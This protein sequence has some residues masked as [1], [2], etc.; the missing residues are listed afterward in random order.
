MKKHRIK[1]TQIYPDTCAI[2]KHFTTRI[3]TNTLPIGQIWMPDLSLALKKIKDNWKQT[4]GFWNIILKLIIIC[5]AHGY[6]I[7]A[8]GYEE[9]GSKW[10]GFVKII[11]VKKWK[12]TSPDFKTIKTFRLINVTPLSNW[13][14]IKIYWKEI[15]ALSIICLDKYLIRTLLEYL[16]YVTTTNNAKT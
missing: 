3:Y 9:V 8:K 4:S 6:S 14:L 5:S 2:N 10:C 11:R 1:F 13:T 15:L 16:I 7:I 12:I